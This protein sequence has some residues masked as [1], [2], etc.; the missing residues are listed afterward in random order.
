MG[1]SGDEEKSMIGGQDDDYSDLRR[2]AYQCLD[3]DK[4]VLPESRALHG[5]GL[6]LFQVM[7]IK[8]LHGKGVRSSGVSSG[9]VMIFIS[10]VCSE[11]WRKVK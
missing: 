7:K 8:D 1:G 9:K 4:A 10:H 6:G 5:K 3:H 2:G 11:K